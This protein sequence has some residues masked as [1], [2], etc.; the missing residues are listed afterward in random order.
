[1]KSKYERL[2]R[3][4]KATTQSVYYILLIWFA[5][6]F[7][8]QKHWKKTCLRFSKFNF[9]EKLQNIFPAEMPLSENVFIYY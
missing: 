2:N 8:D 4:L 9:S 5:L 1:M 3:I 7:S 6:G